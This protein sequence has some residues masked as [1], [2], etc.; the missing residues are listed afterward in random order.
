MQLVR[1][2]AWLYVMT[3]KAT[4]A[5]QLQC[6]YG[7]FLQYGNFLLMK[8]P[9]LFMTDGIFFVLPVGTSPASVVS[10]NPIAHLT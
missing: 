6:T 10:N 7:D 4:D 3:L 5:I 1:N 9:H 8:C 2:L